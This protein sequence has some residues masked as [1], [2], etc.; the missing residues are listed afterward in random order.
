MNP[1]SKADA[2]PSQSGA[3]HSETIR[4]P[5]HGMTCGSCVVRITRAL[6]GLDGIERIK[7]DLRDETVMVRRDPSR[8][9]DDVVAAAIVEAGYEPDLAAAQSVAENAR[10][11]IFERWLRR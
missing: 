4:F 9:S 10:R 7:V 2:G 8:A 6:K 1:T 3:G 11:R 5:I